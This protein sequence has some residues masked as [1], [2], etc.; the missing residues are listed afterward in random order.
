MNYNHNMSNYISDSLVNL[1]ELFTFHAHRPSVIK[2]DV[3][4]N[5]MVEHVVDVVDPRIR[6]IGRYNQ[7]LTGPLEHTWQYLSEI[8]NMIPDGV[9]IDRQKYS[10]DTRM[11][12]VFESQGYLQTLLESVPP[13]LKDKTGNSAKRVYMLLCME[14]KE[15]SFLGSE[16]VGEIIKRDVL[17]TRMSFANRKFLSAGYS[18]EDAILGFKT[19]SLEGLLQKAHDLILESRSEHRELIERKRKLHQKLQT[20]NVS[21]FKD[22]S[23]F[24]T[25]NDYLSDASPDLLDIERQLTEI[26]IKSESPDHHLSQTIE[27]LKHPE[28]H[29]R[30]EN[31]SA[32]LN[33]AGT[34]LPANLSQKG[35]NIEYA[36]I[37]IEQKLKR[38]VMIVD[39]AAEEIFP[40]KV[41]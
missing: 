16:L 24:F 33:S 12:L 17:Q 37:V 38:I 11:K 34:K 25:R 3:D 10:S 8:A 21:R 23:T 1:R 26:R 7:K 18:K 32:V 9:T 27:L 2:G 29:L 20:T 31:Q 4:I 36:E 35:I 14:K 39:C 6:V 30:L 22:H 15:Q 5:Q 28:L 13:L 19:C 40:E 41:H